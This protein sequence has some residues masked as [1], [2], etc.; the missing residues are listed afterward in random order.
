MHFCIGLK[1]LH[2]DLDFAENW[3]IRLLWWT[4]LANFL[5][6]LLSRENEKCE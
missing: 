2:S 6:K 5:I 3:E 4:A 1:M